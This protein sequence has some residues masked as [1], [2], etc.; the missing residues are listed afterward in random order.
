MKL[1]K[2]EESELLEI[3]D[4]LAA[5]AISCTLTEI[6]ENNNIT[7]KILEK[8]IEVSKKTHII[9]RTKILNMIALNKNTT[10]GMM[11]ELLKL[12][13]GFNLAR[14]ENIPY[15][16]AEKLSESSSVDVVEMLARNETTPGEILDKL[17]R[18]DRFSGDDND[19]IRECAGMNPNL[20]EK[21][22]LSFF[23][24]KEK[25]YLLNYAIDHNN[26]LTAKGLEILCDNALRDLENS[27]FIID[28]IVRRKDTNDELLLK[29]I[30]RVNY[31]NL[32]RVLERKDIS[33]VVLDTLKERV[34]SCDY[35]FKAN[36]LLRKMASHEVEKR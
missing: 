14:R 32:S 33:E 29:I 31:S 3:I 5:H 11:R 20:S 12:G 22:L 4:K 34:D 2:D 28:G 10:I 23:D 8:L 15:E 16:I 1:R 36:I 17:T 24:S 25:H 18:I 21:T 30:K 26:N 27:K 35:N 13:K 19:Y 7:V 6:A 9:N